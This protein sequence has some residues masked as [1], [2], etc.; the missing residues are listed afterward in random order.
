MTLF[1]LNELPD[2][3][4]ASLL[5][6]VGFRMY[7]AQAAPADLTFLLSGPATPASRSMRAR[8]SA[9]SAAVTARS[10]SRPITCSHVA[11]P[12]SARSLDQMADGTDEIICDRSSRVPATARRG[13]V[14]RGPRGG[15][16]AV[17]RRGGAD[18]AEP[19]PALGSHG[20]DSTATPS[21]SGSPPGCPSSTLV[22]LAIIAT[23]RGAA[24]VPSG[25]RSCGRRPRTG[26]LGGVPVTDDSTG[27]S[28]VL[29]RSTSSCRR[30]HDLATINSNDLYWLRLR[31]DVGACPM[32][33]ASPRLIVGRVQHRR[34]RGRARH[35]ELQPPE[36][37]GAQLG[38]T[39][40]A[41]RPP[42]GT[43]PVGGTRSDRVDGVQWRRSTT[44]R[45][46]GRP[47]T[48]MC[49][50]RSSGE[51]PFG[52]AVRSGDGALRQHGAIPP[53]DALIVSAALPG[54]RG[55][56]GNVPA[57]SCGA[58]HDASATSIGS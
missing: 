13:R 16:E 20:N 36:H 52:P 28:T 32:Y 45:T 34:R 46:S 55:E 58:C 15:S 23:T 19:A 44:S 5:D 53:Q 2:R 56:H 42:A 39:G 47:T 30:E 7:P 24:A 1:R 10:S 21:T 29:V 26:R 9:P 14:L 50:I 40:P 12:H 41:V 6:S 49:S 37:V 27:V 35:A 48:S 57:G 51:I 18:V 8:R 54:R 33:R 31:V 3:A 4:M 11:R 38:A 43:P 17:E 25:H 22:R